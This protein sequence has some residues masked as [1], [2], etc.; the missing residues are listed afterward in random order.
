MVGAL[1]GMAALAIAAVLLVWWQWQQAEQ[2]VL[3]EQVTQAETIRGL[4]ERSRAAGRLEE[5]D[6]EA[7]VRRAEGGELYSMT[8]RADDI[9]IVAR[10]G[11][12]GRPAFG[13]PGLDYA[14]FGF[15]VPVFSAPVTIERLSPE[16]GYGWPDECRSGEP[17]VE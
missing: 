17:V 6:V 1:I 2:K 4:L 9:Y 11:A 13:V 5:A 10:V 8:E 7:I 15:N 3:E 14:C 12:H 16:E